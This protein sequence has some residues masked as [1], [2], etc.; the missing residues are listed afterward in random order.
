MNAYE[1][2]KLQYLTSEEKERYFAEKVREL[3]KIDPNGVLN[4]QDWFFRIVV[5]D[6]I[7]S[8]M[9][10]L[11]YWFKNCAW[12]DF[13]T[14]Y[15]IVRKL[16]LLQLDVQS[17]YS[18]DDFDVNR[19]KLFYMSEDYVSQFKKIDGLLVGNTLYELFSG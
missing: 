3:A 6:F 12:D 7:V 5:L 18:P 11:I 4:H 1:K 13:D 2:D 17:V 16:R 14:V 9:R 15:R 19:T 10:R 8:E